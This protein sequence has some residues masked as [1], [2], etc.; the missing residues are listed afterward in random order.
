[1]LL[2]TIILDPLLGSRTAAVAAKMLGRHYIGIE[3][4]PEY[5]N[6]ANHA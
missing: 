4:E 5:L 1:V 3:H 2:V 6:I